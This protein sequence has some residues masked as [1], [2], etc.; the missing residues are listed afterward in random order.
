M[1]K[2]IVKTK[3]PKEELEKFKK[4]ETI[5]YEKALKSCEDIAYLM[6]KPTLTKIFE[7]KGYSKE[8]IENNLKIFTDGYKFDI[9]LIQNGLE[10]IWEGHYW[11]DYPKDKEEFYYV[12]YKPFEKWRNLWAFHKELIVKMRTMLRLPSFW[13]PKTNE[14]SIS[15]KYRNALIEETTK[16]F[17]KKDKNALIDWEY[18]EKKENGEEENKE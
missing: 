13:L 1:F 15:K 14:L 3:L 11:I 12:T 18:K 9:N 10:M 7:K 17:K 6:Q 4:E 5:Q 8:E 16:R 2:I